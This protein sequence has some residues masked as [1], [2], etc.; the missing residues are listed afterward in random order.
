MHRLKLAEEVATANKEACKLK[1]AL[2]GNRSHI[3]EYREEAIID[4]KASI[5]FRRGLEKMGQPTQNQPEPIYLSII[6]PSGSGQE[7][8]AY[9]RNP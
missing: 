6:V 2:E 5:G 3:L 7:L 9:L 1:E 8:P 4:Y